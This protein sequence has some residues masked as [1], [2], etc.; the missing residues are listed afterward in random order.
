MEDIEDI[1]ALLEESLNP[2]REIPFKFENWFLVHPH[3]LHMADVVCPS[4]DSHFQ[5]RAA[6]AVITPKKRRYAIVAII[7][8]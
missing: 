8:D 1:D 4:S 3:S 2:V 6:P 7:V 5:G